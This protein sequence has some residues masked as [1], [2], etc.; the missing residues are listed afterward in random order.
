MPPKSRKHSIRW[1]GLALCLLISA[2][3]A[4]AQPATEPQTQ[5]LLNGLKVLFWPVPGSAD[6]LVKLRIHSGSAF[7][8]SGRSGEMALLG[9]VMF[10]DPETVEYFTEQMGG[11]LAV[12]V[13][14]DSMTIT[15]RGKADQ[16]D[17]ILDI[18]RNAI[19]ATQLTPDVIG[20]VRDARIKML[21]DTAVSP[22][23][24]ADRA[25]A[26]RLFGD[27]PYG[28]QSAGSPED[29]A[30]I[31]R[32]DLMLA[33]QRFLNSNNATLAI[34][35]GI[36][37]SRTLRT[38]KQLFGAWRKSEQVIPSTFR[39]PAAPDSKI[40]LIGTPSPTAELRL[41]LR[42]LSKS[43]PDGLV[44]D[45]VARIA[46]NR[47]QATMP[48]SNKT[49]VSVR[50][51]RYTLPGMF[52]MGTAVDNK[53]LVGTVDSLTKILNSLADTTVSAAELKQA[54]DAV[55]LENA[56]TPRDPDSRPDRWLDTDTYHLTSDQTVSL[57]S[58]SGAE[59]QRVA[60]R[61]FK[62]APTATVIAGDI[63]QIKPLLEG[64]FQ[65][66]VLGEKTSPAPAPKTPTKPGPNNTPR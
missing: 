33:R 22:S 40:L 65:F 62:N 4:V 36:D 3:Y 45:V 63:E 29:V 18:L 50:S 35:G 39:T 2:H 21:H 34:I 10:P 11:R 15:M 31:D 64:H 17:H 5:E 42:G 25:I 12:N 24:T 51:E 14:Y 61:L 28:R 37:Q 16:I 58:I 26:A 9:D 20:R 59:V 57:L 54:V 48:A 53:A 66:E 49:P 47:W 30:R 56:G 7:D 43:D 6:V 27:F 8:L 32:A 41:A 1:L 19:L 38:L 13:N 44:S 23:I 55:V 60:R 46:Q 52:V